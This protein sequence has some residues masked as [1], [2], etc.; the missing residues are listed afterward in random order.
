MKTYLFII[1]FFFFNTIFSQSVTGNI[2]EPK[3]VQLDDGILVY[4]WTESKDGKNLV[5][6]KYN[7]DLVLEKQ[8]T[9]QIPKGIRDIYLIKEDKSLFFGIQQ[10][11]M[12]WGQYYIR[13][14]NQLNEISTLQF[15][16]EEY[17]KIEPLKKD[18]FNIG[19][20]GDRIFSSANNML[21]CYDVDKNKLPIKRIIKWEC[22]LKP[23][24]IQTTQI[25][26]VDNDFVFTY[27]ND[28]VSKKT[29]A[30]YIYCL[31]ANTGAI[32]YKVQL[33]NPDQNVY[34]PS[35]V[36]LNGNKLIVVGNYAEL[37]DKNKI[38]K[39]LNIDMGSDVPFVNMNS[40]FAIEIDNNSG[41]INNTKTNKYLDYSFPDKKK[42][43]WE[44]IQFII[45]QSLTLNES[46]KYCAI[47]ECYVECT[48]AATG[49]HTGSVG[50]VGFIVYKF[51]NALNTLETKFLPK[52]DIVQIDGNIKNKMNYSDV[53][54]V[55]NAMR[56]PWYEPC[57]EFNM[58]LGCMEYSFNDYSYDKTNS[59]STILYNSFG[60]DRIIS[61]PI[62]KFYIIKASAD[63]KIEQKLIPN[64]DEKLGSQCFLR[65]IN[66]AF[67]FSPMKKGATYKLDITKF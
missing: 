10:T 40:F 57:K 9:K 56:M 19:R 29:F 1:S 37:S 45:F 3:V 11:V 43:N 12:T 32:V 47:G 41:K 33:N 21:Y 34:S 42:F 38:K 48:Q 24:K 17:N 18:E 15:D 25:L 2:E 35:N 23:I 8:Y 60:I 58:P 4:G 30:Q 39:S 14:D 66:S 27:V 26:L 28:A 50:P 16:K 59:S 55:F 31:N 51:D 6:A 20:F 52:E 67:V 49:G 22:D 13:L 46:N 5:A 36:I 7:K 44:G 54:N 63:D 64:Q 65:D 61:N 53:L 62:T